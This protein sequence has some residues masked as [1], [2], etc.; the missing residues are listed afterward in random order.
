MVACRREL[1]LEKS[2]VNSVKIM[3]IRIVTSYYTRIIKE[4]AS[5]TKDQYESTK[6]TVRFS[7]FI[8]LSQP[9]SRAMMD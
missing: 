9:L 6:E 2:K 7:Y 8:H 3:S 1:M 5:Q 4:V